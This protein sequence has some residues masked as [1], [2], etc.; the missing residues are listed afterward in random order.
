MKI[1][2]KF[3]SLFILMSYIL[4][5]CPQ[6]VMALGEYG[7]NIALGKPTIGVGYGGVFD[8]SCV[9][10]N[11]LATNATGEGKWAIDLQEIYNIERI[12]FYTRTD[13]DAAWARSNMPIKVATYSDFSDAVE[14][15]RKTAAG[16]FKSSHNAT[17]EPA[18]KGRYIV[19]DSAEVFAEIEVY[20][21]PLSVGAEISYNDL[22][23]SVQKNAANLV[24]SLRIMEA[25]EELTFGAN[26]L[27]TREEAAKIMVNVAGITEP[28]KYNNDFFDVDSESE[29]AP[30]ISLGVNYGYISKSDNFRPSE[31]L[32]GVELA[33]ML[34]CISG[35][36]GLGYENSY[37][38][39]AILADANKFGLFDGFAGDCYSYVTKSDMS[40][41]I[42]NLL[43][44]N[45]YEM[46]GDYIT[47]ADKTFLETEH[48]LKLSV[49]VVT[50]NGISGM[51]YANSGINTDV[52]E[53]D[54]VRYTDLTGFAVLHMGENI[55][56]VA[57]EENEIVALWIN[58]KK[59]NIVEFA[60]YEIEEA[61]MSAFEVEYTDG[62]EKHYKMETPPYTFKNGVADASVTENDLVPENGYI[63]LIDNDNDGLFEVLMVYKPDFFEVEGSNVNEFTGDLL[64][65]S[66]NGETKLYKGDGYIKVNNTAGATLKSSN[67][68]KGSV[69][70]IYEGSNGSVS[71]EVLN[72][73]ATGMVTSNA[74]GSIAIEGKAYQT[75]DYFFDNFAV[76]V[77]IIGRFMLDKN[78]III[79]TPT[80]F[81]GLKS[82]EYVGVVS[83]AAL[84][85]EDTF[86]E[87]YTTDKSF[88]TVHFANSFTVDGIKVNVDELLAEYSESDFLG[89]LV[90]FKTNSDGKVVSVEKEGSS[91][92]EELAGPVSLASSKKGGDGYYSGHTMI[93]LAGEDVPFF[94]IP[95]DSAGVPLKEQA[96]LSLY[97][98]STFDKY[99][100][101][102]ADTDSSVYMYG[103]DDR[104][105]T[106]EFVV[107][108]REY[109]PDNNSHDTIS[110]FSKV[111]HIIVKSVVSNVDE[112]GEEY[113]TIKGI[114]PTTGQN[115][116]LT[117]EPHIKYV[118][119]TQAMRVDSAITGAYTS[120]NLVYASSVP[121]EYLIPFDG[122]KGDY[123]LNYGDV[124][125]YD[126]GAY[127][128][129]SQIERIAKNVDWT[130]DF[131]NYKV[132]Y[133][134]GDSYS[135]ILSTVRWAQSIITSFEE[136][137]IEYQLDDSSQILK[138]S[139][140]PGRIVVVDE[141]NA[142]KNI[143]C[144]DAANAGL[145]I[146]S[147]DRIL[148]QTGS[149]SYKSMIIYKQ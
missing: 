145:Y 47:K 19:L 69:I 142:K 35:Y 1:M 79:Y 66:P 149:G 121:G 100:S 56:Y 76:Q 59:T 99:Y 68:S 86:L 128:N 124:L 6:Q 148:I 77:G 131:T 54:N 36:Y 14:V 115:K 53:I 147:G 18:V 107:R 125:R 57:N 138:L 127:Q 114:D 43:I 63:R 78:N 50:N 30:Y 25:Q 129:V 48:K 21:T 34:L 39:D 72:I 85:F 104:T 37:Y 112:Y 17:F 12:V 51:T 8:L 132:V 139:S 52:V 98:C 44:S 106:P 4:L 23:T 87:V 20:G 126:V 74:K 71:I 122:S 108:K 84:Y 89:K 118:C 137:Y 93:A 60:D 102:R 29:Y 83:K 136:G 3:A 10:D 94:V 16:D 140:F 28:T 61:S 11:N 80:E 120:L 135:N 27:V 105:K 82:G 88:E 41:M 5:L 134:A 75:T 123:K 133:T 101:L 144:Y 110:S 111:N 2:N 91:M 92:R 103:F 7:T 96:Y 143:T 119:D 26:Y 109:S 70:R 141:S 49:G 73:A 45:K 146:A 46:Q 95:T 31:Y 58:D 24:T 13:L 97:N 116:N 64:L 81:E 40:I 117:V 67:V 15:T 38:A 22:A 90:I 130:D 32:T 55:Y 33:K 9:N 42:Y 113:Y 65:S 62:T